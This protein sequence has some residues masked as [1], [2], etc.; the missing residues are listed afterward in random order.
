LPAAHDR[1]TRLRILTNLGMLEVNY[2]SAMAR[3]TWA[4]VETLAFEQHQYLLASRAVGEQGNAVF[5]LGDIATAKK[6]VVRAWMA[7]KVAD[8][9][10]HIRYGSMYGAGLVGIGSS[11]A[12]M[13]IR[14]SWRI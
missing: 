4:E 8:P 14:E 1:E 12:R 7:A 11:T 2:D 13:P 6:E 9:A 5:L 3:R 10:A